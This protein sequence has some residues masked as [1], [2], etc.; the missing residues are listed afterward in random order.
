MLSKPNTPEKR[1]QVY[2]FTVHE[3]I[4]VVVYVLIVS[5]NS[6]PADKFTKPL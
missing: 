6:K 2:E 4:R 1:F 5:C 3:L